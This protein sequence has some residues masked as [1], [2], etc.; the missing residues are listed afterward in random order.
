M[1]FHCVDVIK[2][3]ETQLW[4]R[5]NQDLELEWDMDFD[6]NHSLVIFKLIMLLMH[7]SRELYILASATFLHEEVVDP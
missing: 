1:V 6:L 7:F 5:V 4:D 3:Q 2:I